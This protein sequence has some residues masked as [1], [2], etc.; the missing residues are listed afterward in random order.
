MMK[1]YLVSIQNIKSLIDE[2]IKNNWSVVTEAKDGSSYKPL[3]KGED[4]ELKPDTKPTNQSLKQYYFPRSEPLFY[5][6]RNKENIELIDAVKSQVKTVVI[7]SKPCDNAAVRIIEKV[8]N[9]D[10]KDKFFNLLTENTVFI[11]MQCSYRDEYCFCTSVGLS[12]SS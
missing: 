5:F 9:W 8:F 11:G 10:Y 1:K 6:K 7:G 3:A 4:L 2:L 12:P